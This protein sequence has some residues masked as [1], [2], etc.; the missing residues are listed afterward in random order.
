[1]LTSPEIQVSDLPSWLYVLQQ[2][3]LV[4]NFNFTLFSNQDLSDSDIMYGHPDGWMYTDKGTGGS[5][6][7]NTISD[8]CKIITSSEDGKTMVFSQALH[9]FPKWK[10]T[11]KGTTVS[12]RVILEAS[13][14]STVLVQLSDGKDASAKQVTDSG[15]MILDISHYVCDDATELTLS[16]LC[17]NSSV[18]L[19]ISSTC[20]NIG[21]FAL[22]TLPCMIE[23]VI[24]ERRQYVSTEMPP[25][26]ELSLCTETLELTGPGVG[27]VSYT[28][29][30]S[31]LNGKFGTGSN[32]FSMLPDM[33]GYFSRAWDNDA[34]IDKNAD[35][36]TALGEGTTTGDNVGTVEQDEFKSHNHV[37]SFTMTSQVNAGDV[38]V[39]STNIALTTPSS[40]TGDTGG[41]ETRSINISEL[42]TIKWA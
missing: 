18:A 7:Y 12:A 5:I 38:P 19:N 42:F 8:T 15:E 34:G 28:R 26:T 23:G 3:N 39:P 1:M 30:S 37:L 36:R 2:R 17:S 11:L 32:G 31:Y 20:A 41:D 13:S 33:R 22:E 10:S 16:I 4:Y 35:T 14:D 29:L 6:T 25:A 21:E 9:E 40:N 27:D 24:G